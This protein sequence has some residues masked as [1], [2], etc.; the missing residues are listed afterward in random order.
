MKMKKNKAYYVLFTFVIG[1]LGCS[2]QK[3]WA[4][5]SK[6]LPSSQRDSVLYELFNSDSMLYK[7]S[8]LLFP[9][10]IYMFG[11]NHCNCLSLN[12]N[13]ID[14]SRFNNDYFVKKRFITDFIEKDKKKLMLS[15]K[16]KTP[17]YMILSQIIHNRLI[18]T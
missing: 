8:S 9:F 1:L 17:I 4:Y 12:T 13:A 7:Q 10:D 14:T 2:T 18:M 15:F 6:K 16:L 11:G 5:L 3:D